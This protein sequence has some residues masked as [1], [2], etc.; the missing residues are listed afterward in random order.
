MW[1]IKWKAVRAFAQENFWVH[2]IIG[3][4][5]NA[6]FF[7]GMVL[8]KLDTAMDLAMWLFIVGTGGMLIDTIGSAFARWER[9][10]YRKKQEAREQQREAAAY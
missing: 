3:I 5:G 6:S 1:D 2:T 7:A 9:D 4:L 10:L 8:W